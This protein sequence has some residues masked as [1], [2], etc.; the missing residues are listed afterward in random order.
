MNAQYSDNKSIVE[1]IL[2]S[3]NIQDLLVSASKMW[4]FA[5][6]VFYIIVNRADIF[7]FDNHL[8]VFRF[9]YVSINQP[10]E[11]IITLVPLTVKTE[12]CAELVV[13]VHFIIRINKKHSYTSSPW[14]GSEM[15]TVSGTVQQHL[16]SF[17]RQ[18]HCWLWARRIM[19]ALNPGRWNNA[20]IWA[21]RN[22][23]AEWLDS[24][25]VSK[26][27]QVETEDTMLCEIHTTCLPRT[28]LSF[29][30]HRILA[31]GLLPGVVHVRVMVSPS[32]AGL[33]IPVISGRPGTPVVE[34]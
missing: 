3:K 27:V 18:Q 29:R 10:A 15:W 23:A 7:I 24:N 32:M 2:S 9:I 22:A 11:Y 21:Q 25:D 31:A 33:V 8:L 13:D 26:R 4:E 16:D 28:S 12:H 17:Q 1:V 5:A 34:I 30:N 19:A 6:S 14:S 20:W